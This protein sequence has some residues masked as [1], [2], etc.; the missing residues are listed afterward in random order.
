MAKPIC[1]MIMP[2]STKETGLGPDDPGPT[3]IDFDA[4]WERALG[5]AIEECGYMPVRADQDAGA[6]I[7]VEMIQRLAMSDLV[8]ADISIGNANVYYEIG[9]RHAA[10][11]YGCVLVSASWA[12]V[13]FD[14]DQMPRLVYTL[15]E[16]TINDETAHTI[17][18]QITAGLKG[19]A[20]G[21]SPVYQAVPGFPNAALDPD[22]VT[23]FKADMEELNAILGRMKGIQR[24]VD[25]DGRRQAALALRDEIA[26]AGAIRDGIAIRVMELL[27]DAVGWAEMVEWIEQMP[28]RLRTRPFIQEQKLLAISKSGEPMEAIGALE[29]LIETAGDSSER[30][31]LL[32]GRYKRLYDTSP[33]DHPQRGVYLQ[34]AIHH[35]ERGT[36]L[37]LND[38]YP[39]CN[40]PR[41]YRERGADGD[42]DRA[43]IAGAIAMM[44]CERAKALHP[45]DKWL[46]PTLLGAAFDA[47]AVSKAQALALE[48]QMESPGSWK[49]E[50]T[51]SDLRRATEQASKEN[52]AGLTAIFNQLNAMLPADKRVAELE[53]SSTAAAQAEAPAE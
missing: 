47:E 45:E 39:S 13:L 10:Q 43:R 4:L 23:H 11:Q 53:L 15:E 27:R 46:R 40:L 31:G 35:Y 44:A 49:L 29:R 51:I 41:L 50:T 19:L 9:V 36:K 25:E 48:V 38:Y 24:T 5:P 22:R 8:V 33:P 21:E 34:R 30:Q 7:V 32:G 12:K 42:A 6:L 18:G 16:G 14:I 20:E 1:F 28:E 17:R 26:A 37:D 52:R 2:F 3:T